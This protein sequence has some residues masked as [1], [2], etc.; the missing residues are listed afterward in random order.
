[1]CVCARCIIDAIFINFMCSPCTRF[2][3][4]DHIASR[5]TKKPLNNEQESEQSHSECSANSCTVDLH[6]SVAKL[7]D[8]RFVAASPSLNIQ[9]AYN[10]YVIHYG[11]LCLSLSSMLPIFTFEYCCFC[12]CGSSSSSGFCCCCNCFVAVVVDGWCWCFIFYPFVAFSVGWY[13]SNSAYAAPRNRCITKAES[14]LSW[15]ETMKLP[16]HTQK[17]LA[18]S[19][20]DIVKYLRSNTNIWMEKSSEQQKNR[21]KHKI[22]KYVWRRVGRREVRAEERSKLKWNW[23]TRFSCCAHF[24]ASDQRSNCKNATQ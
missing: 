24:P 6:G 15:I 4:S 20:N 14:A 2:K 8:C 21:N 17:T 7:D 5:Q 18:K 16:A 13:P 10:G 22:Y 3:I 9:M 23:N 19:M 11:R 12:Y 1:M